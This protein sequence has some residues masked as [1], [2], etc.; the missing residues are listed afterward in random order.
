MLL[1]RIRR[2]LGSHDQGSALAAVVGVMGVTLV[3]TTIIASSI[4]TA[5]G[6]TTAT[7]AGVQ[8]QAAAEAGIAAARAGLAAGTCSARS[9]TYSS[10]TGSTPAYLA[11]IWIPGA[12]TWARGC[13]LNTATEVRILSTGYASA[14]GVGGSSGDETNLE[15]VLSA[16]AAT[17]TTTTTTPPTQLTPSGPALYAYSSQG[18]SG[19]GTLVSV[20]GSEPDIMVKTGDVDCSGAASGAADLVV[21]GGSLVLS[22]SCNISG[23]VWSTGST[24]VT[25]GV[26][27][28]G[29]LVASSVSIPSGTVGGS[30]WSAGAVTLSGGSSFIK[31]NVT[32]G[33]LGFTGGGKVVQNAWIYGQTSMDWGSN[34][35]GNLTTKTYSAPAWSSGLVSGSTTTSSPA[36]P[37]ASPYAQPAS[38]I[39]PDW[40]DFKYVASDW[41]GFTE[42]VITSGGACGYPQL[43]SAVASLGTKPGVIN[44]LGCAGGVYLGN[45]DKVALGADLAIVSNKFLLTGSG[46]FTAT[47]AKKLF[48]VTPDT[49]AGKT[50]TCPAGSTF[51]IDGGFTASASISIMMYSP[52]EV[53]LAS[54]L[55]LRGQVFAGKAGISGGATLGYVA[56]GLPGVDLWTGSL[57][58]ST[59]TTTTTTTTGNEA[60]RTLKSLRNVIEGN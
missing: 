54:G 23:N 9:G 28:G 42:V 58:P 45:A 1:T 30:V 29:N 10:A 8:S 39:V 27:V 60:T 53:V 51:A 56:V 49:V 50:P 40:V 7:R 41:T 37:A 55:S 2:A 32:G 26:T 44:A 33:S 20:G 59:P 22:G 21:Q 46:G 34:I 17:T 35:Q 52:C 24:S 43:A 14:D 4:I 47:S 6:H 3:L 36:T 48:L 18:F 57:T 12:G 5:S 15:A 11:T 38:P 25:G 13:P 19:S 31:G 16:G